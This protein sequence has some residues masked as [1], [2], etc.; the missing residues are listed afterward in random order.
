MKRTWIAALVLL[1]CA[2]LAMNE[3]GRNPFKK[4]LN[5][6]H[7]FLTGAGGGLGRLMAVKFGT[8]GCKLSLSDVSMQGLQDTK[9]ECEKNGIPSNHITLFIC[10]VSK[11]ESITAGA[12]IAR[13]AHGPVTLL[14]NNAGIVSGKTTLE[15]TD[16]MIEKTMQ[17]NTNALLYTIREF[18]PDMIKNKKGHIVNIA[19]M[20]GL[21]SVPG[22]GDYCASKHGA[23]AIDESVRLEL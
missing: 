20:A 17:V 15:L 19:S 13:A 2:Y 5:G 16:A 10:D 6:D 18:L 23:I 12:G 11:R 1:R 22:L 14:V 8:L 4:S 21:T 7:V 9:A 3:Y